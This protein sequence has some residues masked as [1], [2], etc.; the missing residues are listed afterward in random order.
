V[1]PH[2]INSN[3]IAIA[4]QNNRKNSPEGNSFTPM[5]MSNLKK[6]PSLV[7]NSS[8]LGGTKNKY[9]LGRLQS[10]SIEVVK[11]KVVNTGGLDVPEFTE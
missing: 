1:S 3:R 9:A 6:D 4:Q 11:Q 2:G 5:R 10:G 8:S 7:N